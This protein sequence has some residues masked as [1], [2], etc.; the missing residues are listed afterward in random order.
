MKIIEL[1]QMFKVTDSRMTAVHSFNF[2]SLK[3]V[4]ILFQMKWYIICHIT[5][6]IYSIG[7]FALF[8]DLLC[9]HMT[10]LKHLPISAIMAAFS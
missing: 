10:Y 7:K 6:K 1:E 4:S 3:N 5:V 9:F 8:D 2:A